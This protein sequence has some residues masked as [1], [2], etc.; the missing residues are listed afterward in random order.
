MPEVVARVR[1]DP[2]PVGVSMEGVGVAP[3]I[4]NRGDRHASGH[5]IV[6]VAVF[7]HSTLRAEAVGRCW[8]QGRWLAWVVDS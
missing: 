8:G 3:A 7:D 5:S 4:P 6:G 1:V 2:D